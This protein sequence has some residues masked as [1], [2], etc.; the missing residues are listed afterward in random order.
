VTVSRIREGLVIGEDLDEVFSAAV[1]EGG[2]ERRDVARRHS[3]EETVG[4]WKEKRSRG[5]GL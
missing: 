2:P 5:L 1:I 3:D 4:I